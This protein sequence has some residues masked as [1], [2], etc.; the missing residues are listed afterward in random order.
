M[1][2]RIERHG[3]SMSMS[4]ALSPYITNE[5][6]DSAAET[7]A[8]Y[9]LNAIRMR[10]VE[11]SEVILSSVLFAEESGNV[12]IMYSSGVFLILPNPKIFPRFSLSF[13]FSVSLLLSSASCFS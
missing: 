5:R 2:F 9:P 11:Y 4:V 12:K 10:V 7:R 13:S 6:V 8:Y 3:T 1:R